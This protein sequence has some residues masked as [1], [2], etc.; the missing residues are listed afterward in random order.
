MDDNLRDK[1]RQLHRVNRLLWLSILSGIIILNVVAF[2]FHEFRLIS[3]PYLTNLALFLNL[4][5][6]IALI[7]LF[8]V[9]YIKR[10]YLTP[11]KLVE[12]AR[13]RNL[14]ITSPDVDDLVK[15]LG[16]KAVWLLKAM[17]IMR[18]YFMVIWSIAN[19]IVLIGFISYIITLNLET[20]FIYSIVGLYSLAINFP[21]FA[22]IESCYHR[23]DINEVED[24]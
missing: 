23:I 21:R 20:F 18:R 13:V 1:T 9:I 17:I 3:P 14:Q 8:L 12:R 2:I 22:L 15:N 11:E 10:N 7:L 16:E 19:L 24:E 4:L 5:L 6:I